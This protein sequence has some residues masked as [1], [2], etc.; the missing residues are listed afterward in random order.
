MEA[1]GERK[2]FLQGLIQSSVG[3]FHGISGNMR[4]SESQLS[5]GIEKLEGYRP[6]YHGVDV[7]SLV[8]QLTNFRLAIRDNIDAGKTE[9]A[10]ALVP[11]MSFDAEAMVEG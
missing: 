2:R 11:T 1:R 3:L 9:V 10:M 4:G 7:D 5:K 6:S 8:S